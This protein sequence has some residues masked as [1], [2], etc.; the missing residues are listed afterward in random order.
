LSDQP[1]APWHAAISP[2]SSSIGPAKRRAARKSRS[3]WIN[4]LRSLNWFHQ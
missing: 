1:L 3:G 2:T 4:R